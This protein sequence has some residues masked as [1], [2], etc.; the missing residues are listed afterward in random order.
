[1]DTVPPALLMK[2]TW[3]YLSVSKILIMDLKFQYLQEPDLEGCKFP[4]ALGDTDHKEKLENVG[5]K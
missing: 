2:G 4:G 3:R 1:M 5:F